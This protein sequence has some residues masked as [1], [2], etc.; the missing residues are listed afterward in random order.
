MSQTAKGGTMLLKSNHAQ[1]KKEEEDARSSRLEALRSDARI[2][3]VIDRYRGFL[4]SLDDVEMD[5]TKQMRL[6]ASSEPILCAV[7]RGIAKIYQEVMGQSPRT[8]GTGLGRVPD[9][10]HPFAVFVIDIFKR[11]G[12][13]PP[14][15]YRIRKAIKKS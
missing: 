10:E 3:Q 8:V 12:F 4:K 15:E 2:R 6:R 11:E 5:L 14:S 7:I 9:G 13:D 1:P